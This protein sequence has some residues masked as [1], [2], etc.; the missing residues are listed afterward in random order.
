METATNDVAKLYDKILDN[1]ETR[2]ANHPM[3]REITLLTIQHHLSRQDSSWSPKFIA[4]IGGGPG[5]VAFALADNGNKVDLVD[6]SPGLIGLAQ[7]EQDRRVAMRNI[8]T[9]ETISVGNALDDTDLKEALY[10]GVLLLGPL[11][12]L[13]REDERILAVKNGLKLAKPHGGLVFCAFTSIA[14][15]LRD[16]AVRDPMRLVKNR[17]FYDKY[18]SCITHAW[19]VTPRTNTGIVLSSW[20]AGMKGST[21]H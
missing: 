8:H 16:L 19:I 6:I 18:V 2:L 9:L 4:D 11:Y 5:K 12:H 20:M 7:K 10:D 17:E 21:A 15:H 1:E 13:L 3:E 14:A